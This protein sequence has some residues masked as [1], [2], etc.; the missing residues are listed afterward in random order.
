MTFH[1]HCDGLI[2]QKK[3]NAGFQRYATTREILVSAIPD[4]LPFA[5][6]AVLPLS[7][8]TAASALFHYLDL[9]YPSVN[10]KPTGKSILIWGGSSSVG[11]SAVQLARAAGLEVVATAGSANIEY[12]KSLGASHVFDHKDPDV[13]GK[14]L[15]VLKDGDFVFDTIS[16]QSTQLASAGI[17]G[18]L[19]GGKF[20]ITL[21]PVSGLPDN[22]EGVFGMYSLDKL[23]VCCLRVDS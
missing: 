2:T 1:S 13:V 16:S 8:S 21:P 6:A 12:V 7:V 15:G 11:S 3:P 23:M 9:P 18:K 14:I 19:G 5:N 20:P 17:L 10:P 4:N 22:V